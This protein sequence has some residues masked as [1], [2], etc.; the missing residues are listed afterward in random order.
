MITVQDSV[1][2]FRLMTCP[3]VPSLLS[4]TARGV[5]QRPRL[6]I[7]THIATR[8]QAA[9]TLATGDTGWGSG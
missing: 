1:P 6:A 9:I 7:V 3:R 8:H 5:R 4:A 2:G